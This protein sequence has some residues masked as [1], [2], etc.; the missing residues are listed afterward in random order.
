MA[1]PGGA[2]SPNRRSRWLLSRSNLTTAAPQSNR[3]WYS[4]HCLPQR[5]LM[6]G[7]LLVA[8]TASRYPIMAEGVKKVIY[9]VH[10]DDND[11]KAL[12]TKHILLE[13][14]MVILSLRWPHIIAQVHLF[15]LL[16]MATQLRH[17]CT[18]HLRKSQEWAMRMAPSPFFRPIIVP[19]HLSA[20]YLYPYGHICRGQTYS[21][22]YNGTMDFSQMDPNVVRE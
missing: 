5:W 18:S 7:Q 19:L 6:R 11:S 10:F 4:L 17:H 13:D 3:I 15:P 16:P 1:S 12:T 21:G 8:N 20:L 2:P 9:P 22:S 14:I